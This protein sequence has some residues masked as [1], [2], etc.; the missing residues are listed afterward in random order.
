MNRDELLK[1]HEELCVEAREL[2]SRKNHDYAGGGNGDHPFL[3]FERVAAMG[4][5]SS[6]SGFLVRM[7]DKMSRLA[8]FC[9]EGEFLVEDEGLRDTIL[10]LINYGVLL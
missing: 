7:V 9:Q 6:D 3:N 10:D 8:T 2:M 5:T 4:I 1:L